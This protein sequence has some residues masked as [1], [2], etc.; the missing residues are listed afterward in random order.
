MS[1]DRSRTEE[2]QSGEKG[3]NNPGVDNLR[4][5][6]IA[7]Y[8]RSQLGAVSNM[9]GLYEGGASCLQKG[10]PGKAGVRSIMDGEDYRALENCCYSNCCSSI[11]VSDT[12]I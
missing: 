3:L 10:I 7:E 4:I 8:F 2:A 9:Y 11:E 5:Q 12:R 1:S 6:S